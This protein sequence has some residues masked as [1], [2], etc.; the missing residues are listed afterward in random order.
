MCQLVLTVDHHVHWVF[1]DVGASNHHADEDPL[2]GQ[3]GCREQQA[4]VCGHADT[5]LVL[6]SGDD[7][8]VLVCL[9]DQQVS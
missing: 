4:G 3:L 8:D 5:A 9:L 1:C 6:I 7:C 2:V